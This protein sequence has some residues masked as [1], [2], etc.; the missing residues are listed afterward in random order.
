MINTH[1]KYRIWITNELNTTDKQMMTANQHNSEYGNNT[2]NHKYDCDTD[3]NDSICTD[4]T[5]NANKDSNDSESF[6]FNP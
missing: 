6:I 1:D 4:Y 5:S 3:D 2:K